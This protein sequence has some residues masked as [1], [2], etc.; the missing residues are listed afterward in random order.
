MLEVQPIGVLRCQKRSEF[1]TP[2]QPEGAEALSHVELHPGH[3]FEVA[4]QGLEKFTRIWLIWWFDRKTGWKPKVLPPRGRSG[5]QGVFATRSPHR[6]NAV[7]M[8]PVRLHEIKERTLTVSEH[9]LL[10]GTP[11]LDIKPYIPRF[12][13]FPNEA[14]GWFAQVEREGQSYRI[15]LSPQAKDQFEWLK[16]REP[17]L[18]PRVESLLTVDPYPHRTRRIVPYEHGYRM[19][20][21]D[22]R[23]YYTL[24]AREVHISEITS[25]FETRTADSEL[26][27]E[28]LT[29]FDPPESKS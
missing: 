18:Q 2:V 5:R 25:R 29:R 9:D 23:L 16:S 17:D 7:G 22:W 20:C 27:R 14:T 8:T 12:D 28:F 26:H 4:L 6:P 10:D 11:I 24:H 15:Q 3:N 13:S 21:G 19:S 1:L